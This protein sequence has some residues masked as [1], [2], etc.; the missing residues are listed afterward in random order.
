MN[1]EKQ[2]LFMN[3]Q[4]PNKSPSLRYAALTELGTM[5]MLIESLEEGKMYR[6][7]NLIKKFSQ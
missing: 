1:R 6:N 4:N 7:G 3:F 2:E 5:E